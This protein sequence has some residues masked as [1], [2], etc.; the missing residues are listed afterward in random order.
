MTLVTY[1][2]PALI[3]LL[4]A[5]AA[6]AS[7]QHY[8]TFTARVWAQPNA[9]GTVIPFPRKSITLAPHEWPSAGGRLLHFRR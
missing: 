4:A 2:Q 3:G 5:Q 6:M 9:F 1:F 8:L 7:W